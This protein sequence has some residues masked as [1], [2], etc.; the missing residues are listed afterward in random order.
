MLD[1]SASNVLDPE[2]GAVD[3]LIGLLAG[4]A[5]TRGLKDGVE[6][7]DGN[8]LSDLM[9]EVGILDGIEIKVVAGDGL[10]DWKIF[11]PTAEVEAV[12]ILADEGETGSCGR[13]EV[14]DS[15]RTLLIATLLAEV[16]IGTDDGSGGGAEELGERVESSQEVIQLS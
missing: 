8:G 2:I 4:L 1:E 7:V 15:V 6:I 13:A 16:V 14:V 3:S 11:P 5:K 9:E 10:E 12:W